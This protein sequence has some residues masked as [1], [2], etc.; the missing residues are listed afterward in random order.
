[1][2]TYSIS[3]NEQRTGNRFNYKTTTEDFRRMRTFVM[4]LNGTRMESCF[5]SRLVDVLDDIKEMEVGKQMFVIASRFEVYV[6]PTIERFNATIA[7]MERAS[8]DD[9]GKNYMPDEFSAFVVKRTPSLWKFA[10]LNAI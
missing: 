3:F 9:L 2:R 1:M 10:T 8:K 7:M 4:R 6:A 5:V